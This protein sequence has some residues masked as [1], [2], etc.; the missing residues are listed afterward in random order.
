[1]ASKNPETEQAIKE[2]C[3]DAALR[4]LVAAGCEERT[5]IGGLSM[6]RDCDDSWEDLIGQAWPGYRG[7]LKKRLQGSIKTIRDCAAEIRRLESTRLWAYML[8]VRCQYPPGSQ[9]EPF[10]KTLEFY[11]DAWSQVIGV[12]GPKKHVFQA[13][14]KAWLVAYVKET[15]GDWH[16]ERL[17]ALIAAV[18]DKPCDT[19]ALLQWRHENEDLIRLQQAELGQTNR[20]KSD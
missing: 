17:S 2:H 3:A 7:D 20:P 15:T 4:K 9:F 18:T 14:V 16:D 5:L 11:A 1:M 10:S 19:H 12:V 6:M 13:E 8:A